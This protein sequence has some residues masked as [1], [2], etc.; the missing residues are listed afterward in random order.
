M[1]LE[2]KSLSCAP[3]A[4]E[5]TRPL[6]GIALCF[7]VEPAGYPCCVQKLQGVNLFL[8]AIEILFMHSNPRTQ[9]RRPPGQGT[10]LQFTRPF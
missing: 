1:G 2:T 8:Q 5:G 6:D 9:E 10:G 4:C 7:V 3:R